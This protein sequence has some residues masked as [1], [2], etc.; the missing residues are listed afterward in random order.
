MVYLSIFSP[1]IQHAGIF[2]ST[3]WNAPLGIQTDSRK[4]SWIFVLSRLQLEN[5]PSCLWNLSYKHL[6]TRHIQLGVC[7]RAQDWSHDWLAVWG[8]WEFWDLALLGQAGLRFCC[9]LDGQMVW[10]WQGM[11]ILPVSESP[12]ASW[13][14]VLKALLGAGNIFAWLIFLGKAD[15]YGMFSSELRAVIL[16]GESQGLSLGF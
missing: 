2:Q 1:G 12:A 15:T 13:R 10:Q 7:R 11:V 14:W 4:T 3:G 8:S 5:P 6:W 9:W 16:L